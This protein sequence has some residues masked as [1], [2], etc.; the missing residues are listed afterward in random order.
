MT[1][2]ASFFTVLFGA[3]FA[4]LFSSSELAE[5]AEIRISRERSMAEASDPAAFAAYQ[6][7]IKLRRAGRSSKLRHYYLNQN[8]GS[9]AVKASVLRRKSSDG[10]WYGWRW[11][12]PYVSSNGRY[13]PGH[14]VPAN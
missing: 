13:V 12:R 3:L 14:F 6:Q 1:I 7:R 10:K 4:A 11:V 8:D 9:D 5:S 2:K